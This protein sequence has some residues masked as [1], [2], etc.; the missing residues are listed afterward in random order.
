MPLRHSAD[1][2]ARP[3]RLVVAPERLAFRLGTR[4]REEHSMA[5]TDIRPELRKRFLAGK[6]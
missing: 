3:A 6:I 5:K 2:N 4:G 1:A